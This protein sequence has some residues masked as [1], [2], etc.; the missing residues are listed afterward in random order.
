MQKTELIIT[1]DVEDFFSPIAS[2]DLIFIRRA[3]GAWGIPMIMDICERM[4]I[5]A[6]FF[7]DVYNVDKTG[8]SIIREACSE[9]YQRGHEVGLHTHPPIP[10]QRAHAIKARIMANYSQEEQTEL[11]RIGQERI[12]GYIGCAPLSHRAGSYG[13]NVETLRALETNGIYVDASF[14]WRHSI[15]RLNC[16]IDG[17]VNRPCFIGRVL[18]VP[19]T[20]TRT[21]FLMPGGLPLF[22]MTKKIDVNWCNFDEMRGQIDALRQSGITPIIIFLHSYSFVKIT[23]QLYPVLHVCE[24]FRKLLEDLAAQRDIVFKTISEFAIQYHHILPISDTDHLPEVNFEISRYRWRDFKHIYW[25]KLTWKNLM[26]F[27]KCGR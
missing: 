2:S 6:T 12:K 18:E 4:G 13:A 15:C 9:I 27:R 5:K 23:P 10:T 8:E 19:V 3:D 22:S 20:V 11:I 16:N 17:L 1:V 25:S 7:V 21:R 26:R 14:F 24:D